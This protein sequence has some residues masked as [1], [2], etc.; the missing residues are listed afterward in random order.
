MEQSEYKMVE[1]IIKALESQA[2]SQRRDASALERIQ[3][4]L[5]GE[6]VLDDQPGRV[7]SESQ[8]DTQRP[9]NSR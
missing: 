8:G 3:D 9:C 5:L 4:I 2:E 7:D 1:R 6:V